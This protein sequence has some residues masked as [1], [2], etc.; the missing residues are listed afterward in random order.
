ML[1]FK[2]HPLTDDQN[3]MKIVPF[4]VI[5]LSVGA[6]QDENTNFFILSASSP[7]LN[8]FYKSY[9]NEGSY[10]LFSSNKTIEAKDF[11]IEGIF[12]NTIPINNKKIGEETYRYFSNVNESIL[13]E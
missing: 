4:N 11:Q 12:V 7:V 9:I 1:N 5:K 13:S 8:D 2:K 6:S 3:E 10:F